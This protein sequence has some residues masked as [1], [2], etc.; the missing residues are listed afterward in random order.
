MTGL[1]AQ[2]TGIESNAAPQGGGVNFNDQSTLPV[3]SHELGYRT[4]L[5]GKDRTD[6]DADANSDAQDIMQAAPGWDDYFAVVDSN[7]P[8]FRG[9]YTDN[10]QLVVTGST[11]QDYSTDRLSRE[12]NE[13]IN[14]SISTNTVFIFTGDNGYKWH[15]HCFFLG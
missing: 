13:F 11:E 15:C 8:S 5:F 14:S 1:Y 3:W 12:T 6:P 2:H 10:G 7:F 4:G 9:T